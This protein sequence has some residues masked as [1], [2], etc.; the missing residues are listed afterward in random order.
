MPTPNKV[1][2][3]V[4]VSN[5]TARNLRSILGENAESPGEVS[6]YLE[7][8]VAR[9]ILSQTIRQIQER[10]RHLDSDEVEREVNKA[11]REV[12]QERYTKLLATES[13]V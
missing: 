10:N 5:K 6:R 11:V 3:T 9:D 7:R 12:R 2:F 13:R 8:A 4:T 1:E